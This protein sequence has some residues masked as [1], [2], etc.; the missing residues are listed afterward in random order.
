MSRARSGAFRAFLI[1]L[2]AWAAACGSEPTGPELPDLEI[3]AAGG[4]GQFGTPGQR[5]DSPLKALVRRLDTGAPLSGIA[6][7]WTVV[8]GDATLTPAGTVTSSTDAHG[9]ASATVQLGT[10]PGD[11]RIRA[12]VQGRPT[13]EAHFDAFVVDR[14][15]L[16]ELTPLNVAPGDT[17]TVD[18][19]GFSPVPDQNVVLFSGIRGR[20]VSA[21]A[22]RLR[23]AV[24][25]CLP[26]RGVSVTAQLGSLVSSAL[27]L[28]VLAGVPPTLTLEPG[29]PVDVE[30]A[31]GY[32]CLRLPAGRRYL[33]LA[34]SAGTVGGARYGFSL[35]GLAFAPAAPVA[36]A[37]LEAA[38]RTTSVDL[39][40]PASRF[41]RSLRRSEEQLL[42][43]G[44]TTAGP[45]PGAA[46]EAVVPTVGHQ[47]SFKVYNGK[48]GFDDV[49]AVARFVS[50]QAVLYVD[51]A[52]P[53][54]GFRDGD[55]QAFATTFDSVI[56]PT[57]TGAFGAPSDLDGNERV[58]IL[59]TPVVNRLTSPGSEGFVGGFF[60][61]LDLMNR[62][63]SN[64]GEIFYALVPDSA[65]AYSD[66][67]PRDLVLRI[68]PAVLAH[69][70]QHM[71]HYNERVLK[72]GAEGTE[73]LWLAEGLAQMAEELVA[74]VWVERGD[75]AQVEEF[76]SGNRG[77]ARRYL[78]DPGSVSLIVAAGQGTLAERGAGWLFVL[79]LWDRWG[80]DTVLGA[81]TRTTLT[82]TANVAAVTGAPWADV[83]ADWSAALYTATQGARYAFD[84]P[85]AGLPSL[86]RPPASYPLSAEI[87][88]AADF[89]RTGSLWSSSVRH[90]I[91]IPPPSGYVALRLGGESGGNAPAEARVRLRV[92]PLH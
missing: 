84:Y 62:E 47:R 37:P 44:R 28:Q 48:G 53:A 88:G 4:S 61:G 8:S 31:G 63:G 70:F 54:G 50:A 46:P 72:L 43:E 9:L 12:A 3:V 81:L 35:R 19:A 78:S 20:V 77:R 6:V 10:A 74:R 13:A 51:E 56:H 26:P 39:L 29:V 76:R 34:Q 83:L 36:P 60:Y 21:T 67:R 73:A 14:P 64:Q 40:D 15:R 87:L 18:G 27:T 90:Y 85:A 55:L 91:V 49:R 16:T 58:V 89:T 7:S 41:E 69:E 11:V 45:S 80:R 25:T 86:L 17:V 79:Y 32:T 52:A 82:G 66:P 42:R 24:P 22:T 30:D 23:V 68:T 33:V 92:V 71:V 57:V 1:L 38:A 2:A 65:G 75:F 5:L 59:F